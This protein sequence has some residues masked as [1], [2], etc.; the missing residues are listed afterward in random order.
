MDNLYLYEKYVYTFPG[1]NIHWLTFSLIAIEVVILFYQ[2]IYYQIRP[3]DTSRLWYLFLLA[4][5]LQYNITGG[6]FIDPTLPISISTQYY[7][8]YG[9]GVI[10][11]MYFPFYIYK[12]LG[13][14][15]LKF[16]AYYGSFFFLLLPFVIVFVIPYSITKDIQF[17]GKWIVLVPFI[18]AFSLIYALF[19]ALFISLK[20]ANAKEDPNFKIKVLGVCVALIF[21]IF[22][23]IGTTFFNGT[24]YIE[25]CLTNAGFLVMTVI[26]VRFSVL[27]SRRE[28]EK[29]LYSENELQKL[30]NLL[31]QKV[32]ERTKELELVV[33]QRTNT[34]ISLAHEIKTPLTLIINYVDEYIST[35]GTNDEIKVIKS[36]VE[37]LKNKIIN[38]FNEEK[39]RKGLSPY[40]HNQVLNFSTLLSETLNSFT[41]YA[42]KKNITL[43]FKIAD[44]IYI[45]ADPESLQSII[46]NLIEN[47][48]KFTPENGSI[49]VSLS[50][51]LNKISFL[52]KDTGCGIKETLYKKIFEPYF[53]IY[54]QNFHGI[55]LGLS[56]VN[57]CVNSLGGSITVKSQE[58][59]GSEF[60]VE[61][62][63]HQLTNDDVI[64][65]NLVK[66]ID[67]TVVNDIEDA[68]DE[69]SR[70]PS[71]LILEDNVDMLLYLRTKL[72]THYNVYVAENGK[73]GLLKLQNVTPD[74]I[75]S[76]VM[77][78]ELDGINFY[79]NLIK[80]PSCAHIPIIFLTAKTSQ[81]S[82]L[83]AL[84][85]GAIDYIF[86]PFSLNELLFK[87]DSQL[88]LIRKQ[89]EALLNAAMNYMNASGIE[90]NDSKFDD[91]LSK[92][93]K[94]CNIYNITQREK[95]IIILISEGFAYK[96]IGEK[97]NV[98]E[99][100][101]AKHKQNIFT[102]LSVSNKIELLNK[103]M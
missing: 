8:S 47:A 39:F 32:Q 30:N 102:K 45:K 36:N 96:E 25:H 76:D 82:K 91:D 78:G 2:I 81:E 62:N 75:I 3:A 12:F 18:Y 79:K 56:I 48:I 86:K 42:A 43:T 50:S 33:E 10:T 29:L 35:H 59:V 11:S 22:G 1:T 61:L 40:S 31:S 92:F 6:L 52:V 60:L 37:S 53:Q 57:N 99:K 98:S 80:I 70:R 84:S 46:N 64:I 66:S 54:S 63:E 41:L 87:I 89:K 69:K 58:N 15:R 90:I 49:D 93:D 77:M 94:N 20:S 97:L 103:L 13:I 72:K 83:Q 71:I 27:D 65:D 51:T 17:S 7:I 19:K 88:L 23:L 26:F 95:E 44:N 14:P 34:F 101:I 21:W 5:I 74:I 4:L 24:Q 28:Y 9:S 85:L 100:T 68:V 67:P 55:G 16:Y 38:F 73:K